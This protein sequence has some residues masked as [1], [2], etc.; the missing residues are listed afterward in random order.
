MNLEKQVKDVMGYIHHFQEDRWPI[1]VPGPVITK[2]KKLGISLK[3]DA[4]NN[5]CY[6][7]NQSDIPDKVLVVYWR[8]RYQECSD[9]LNMVYKKAQQLVDII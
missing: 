6:L 2:L 7:E 8:I 5:R 4:Q 9:H 3:Q 1:N